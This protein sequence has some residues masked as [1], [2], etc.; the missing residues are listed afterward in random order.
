MPDLYQME[1]S[2]RPDVDP[3][4]QRRLASA[5]DPIR[6]HFL[7]ACIEHLFSSGVHARLAEQGEASVSR[8]SRDLDLDENRLTGLLLF[9]ANEEVVAVRDGIVSLTQKGRELGE[10]RSWYRFLIGGYGGTVN[11]IGQALRAGAPACSRNGEAVGVGSCEIAEYDGL[12]MVH[13]LL[14]RSQIVPSRLLD[15]GCG[16]GLYLFEL[17]KELDG[18]TAWGV[19]PDEGAFAAARRNLG[20]SGLGE[21]VTL[22]NRGAREF[23][24]SPPEDCEPDFVVFGYVLQEILGQDGDDALVSVLTKL[25]QTYP[26]AHVGVIEVLDAIDSPEAMEHPVAKAFWNPYFLIHY[27]T[28][29]RLE[30]QR[31]WED[32][33]ERTGYEIVAGVTTADSVDSSGIELG[34]V[35]RA[36]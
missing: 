4:F 26:T 17:L 3:D 1:A 35:L 33:F 29:Q 11:E 2:S 15:L 20:S 30:S 32:L 18:A 9:L 21:R 16:S 6:Q 27:F 12:A 36:S 25:R 19:E 14:E 7:A 23:L 22:V 28:D 34:Y 31:Y 13:D 5:I 24:E 8:L 10:F